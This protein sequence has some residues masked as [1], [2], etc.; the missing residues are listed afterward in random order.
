MEREGPQHGLSLLVWIRELWIIK[1]FKDLLLVIDNQFKL[2]LLELPVDE[3][4]VS[5]L[6]GFE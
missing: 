2:E 5:L 3:F 4:L 1:L 6:V